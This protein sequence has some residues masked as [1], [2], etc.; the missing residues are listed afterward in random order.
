MIV[1]ENISDTL[2]RHYSDAKKKIRQIETGIIYVEAVD[3]LPCQYT[4]E[5]VDEETLEGEKTATAT[6]YQTAL[7][8]LGVN[9]DA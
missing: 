8:S 2:V 9:F 3:I 5:E 6:D 1:S 7:E 4:Y